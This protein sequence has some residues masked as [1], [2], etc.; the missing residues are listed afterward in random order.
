VVQERAE[1][2]MALAT[3]QGFAWQW[4][5]AAFMR[6]WALVVQGQGEEGLAQMTQGLVAIQATGAALGQPSWL[7][8]LAEAHGLV[9]QANEG[10]RVV[11][12]ALALV[13]KHGNRCNAAELYRLQGELLLTLSVEQHPEAASCFHQALDIARRQEAK[14]WELR[15]ATSLARLWQN[16]G[17][18]D[19]ARELL[20]PVYSWF[21]EGFDTADLKDAKV[22][23]EELA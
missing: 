2:L 20:E 16:Q 23:L 21:T 6:G 15:A 3:E 1:T 17:K 9:G 19:E 22:V 7:A 5:R 4:A 13:D 10:L 11:A 12:E 8:T 18:R 14:S